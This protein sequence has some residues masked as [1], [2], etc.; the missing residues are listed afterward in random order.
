MAYLF[1]LKDLSRMIG[2]RQQEYGT[3]VE[4]AKPYFKAKMATEEVNI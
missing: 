2:K 1:S 3:S 4:E